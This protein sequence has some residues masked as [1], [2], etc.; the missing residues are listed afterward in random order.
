MKKRLCLAL[1]R[2]SLLTRRKYVTFFIAVF[3]SFFAVNSASASPLVHSEKGREKQ[4]LVTAVVPL[5]PEFTYTIKKNSTLSI[6][7]SAFSLGEKIHVQV[8]VFAGKSETLGRHKITLH[9][10]NVHQEDVGIFSGETDKKGEVFF[11]LTAQENFLGIITLSA[12]DETYAEPLI[13]TQKIQFIVYQSDDEKKQQEKAIK[14]TANG[15][16]PHLSREVLCEDTSF[17]KSAPLFEKSGTIE[18]SDS[19]FLFPRAGPMINS[20]RE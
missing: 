13:L 8:K 1:I 6:D 4:L 7:K 9:G 3:L 19:N 11:T 10:V 17:Q 18:M 2:Q 12:I 20:V 14:C 16:Q 15:D 5:T